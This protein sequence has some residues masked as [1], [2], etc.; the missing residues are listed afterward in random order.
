[1]VKENCAFQQCDGC[2]GTTMRTITETH[3][4]SGKSMIFNPSVRIESVRTASSGGGIDVDGSYVYREQRASRYTFRSSVVVEK[5]VL[6]S[7]PIKQAD[8][9]F[10]SKHFLKDCDSVDFVTIEEPCPQI[11]AVK[12]MPGSHNDQFAGSCDARCAVGYALDQ[13]FPVAVASINQM[14]NDV[15]P[16]HH[17]ARSNCRHHVAK[18][19]SYHPIEGKSHSCEARQPSG[20]LLL[21]VAEATQPVCQTRAPT[22]SQPNYLGGH[23]D[24]QLQAQ[25]IKLGAAGRTQVLHQSLALLQ[26]ELTV[27]SSDDLGRKEARGSTPLLPMSFPLLKEDGRTATLCEA[28]CNLGHKS[29]LTETVAPKDLARKLDAANSDHFV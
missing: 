21:V 26:H 1:V 11:R 6:F 13:N 28:V 15:L 5:E 25:R 2:T 20:A 17:P 23:R 3:Q 16:L 4:A 19:K 29:S 12:E 22:I 9:G 14:R 10:K 7:A 27:A 18:E 8:D 24:R